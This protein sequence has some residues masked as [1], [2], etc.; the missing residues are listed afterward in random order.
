MMQKYPELY[1]TYFVDKSDERLGLFTLLA[2]KFNVKS[3]LYPGS[4]VHITPSL[5]I[6]EMVYADMDRRCKRFYCDSQ[7]AEFIQRNKTYDQKSVYSFHKADFT[8]GLPLKDESFDLLISFYAGFISKYCGRYLKRGKILLANNSH[9]DAPL[10][11]LD[12]RFEF[13]G[14]INR[15]GNRFSWSETAL[16]TFFI[17]KG[18]KPLDA[19]VI[20]QTMKGPGYTR[21][22]YAYV[23]VK[24]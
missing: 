5:V 13:V 10:A 3:G 6:P 7:T 14:V 8:K 20:E 11:H 18:S 15:N 12:T 9:G 16:D 2:K 19:Q 22:A 21:T 4:F 1:R 17:P 23:F 24:R